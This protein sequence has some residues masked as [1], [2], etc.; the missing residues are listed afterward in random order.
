MLCSPSLLTLIQILLESERNSPS[1]FRLGD[2][3][4]IQSKLLRKVTMAFSLRK[5]Y[6]K[7][8]NFIFPTVWADAL[9]LTSRFLS[10]V[11]GGEKA[12]F[13]NRQTRRWRT[14]AGSERESGGRSSHLQS[15]RETGWAAA[16]ELLVLR[17]P[18][19]SRWN[20]SSDARM[21]C[22]MANH[23]LGRVHHL[24]TEPKNPNNQTARS[25]N[26]I[27]LIA[28]LQIKTLTRGI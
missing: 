22:N 21:K 11:V 7:T 19:S 25:T 18:L 17:W 6:N 2:N 14:D 20:A 15:T 13:P 3:T 27:L 9:L 28:Y 10:T 24:E 23:V 12:Y 1:H 26:L 4:S 8:D 5:L 16:S